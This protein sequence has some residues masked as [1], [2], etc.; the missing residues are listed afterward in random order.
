MAYHT[1]NSMARQTYPTWWEK[2]KQVNTY[3]AYSLPAR[4]I[5]WI[6]QLS[7][8]ECG[9][10]DQC[11]ILAWQMWSALVKKFHGYERDSGLDNFREV[12]AD[13]IERAARYMPKRAVEFIEKWETDFLCTFRA[14]NWRFRHEQ[15][16]VM[17][18]LLPHGP[19][20]LFRFARDSSLKPEDVDRAIFPVLK[21]WFHWADRALEPARVVSRELMDYRM[22]VP[23]AFDG[24]NVTDYSADSGE[25]RD[26]SGSDTDDSDVEEILEA[27]PQTSD[28]QE[29]N[30]KASTNHEAYLKDSVKPV[31][32]SGNDSVVGT[33]GG[34]RTP[35]EGETKLDPSEQ[36]AEL[37]LEDLPFRKN[38]FYSSYPVR[39][40][41]SGKV[42]TA[43][44]EVNKF[45]FDMAMKLQVPLIDI[46]FDREAYLTWPSFQKDVADQT[47]NGGV[48]ELELPTK[49][50]D[51]KV[52]ALWR[53]ITLVR[54]RNNFIWESLESLVYTLAEG[55]KGDL[56]EEILRMVVVYRGI[57]DSMR[58][59]C[60]GL[61]TH[62]S[63]SDGYIDAAE[64]VRSAIIL[65]VGCGNPAKFLDGR[66]YRKYGK[67]ALSRLTPCVAIPAS[68]RCFLGEDWLFPDPDL[69]KPSIELAR[70]PVLWEQ[71]IL[72]GELYDQYEDD[73]P[74]VGKVSAM[75]GIQNGQIPRLISAEVLE[76]VGNEQT[77]GW[78]AAEVEVLSGKASKKREL[79]F[80]PAEKTTKRQMTGSGSS[81]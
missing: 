42:V 53:L 46:F 32:E 16:A 51:D 54:F 26:F 33:A 35:D 64:K 61:L 5:R 65:L 23:I 34:A 22:G 62:E 72:L 24:D 2:L 25:E 56:K 73:P 17:M 1:E 39:E 48:G 50:D 78:V 76:L 36:P 55:P 79:V 81:S 11:M 21:L 8:D 52:G 77:N 6:L 13:T 14:Q 28:I 80:D 63:T 30:C 69:A 66:Y 49:L 43:L 37:H 12:Q 40:V 44:N 27:K 70:N 60:S 9:D 57:I 67:S 59:G 20:R 58:D 68:I 45:R 38:D 10:F 74:Q 47:R 75:L 29:P 4:K 7:F 71:M 41:A 3:Y 18:S 19:R 15:L 31:K